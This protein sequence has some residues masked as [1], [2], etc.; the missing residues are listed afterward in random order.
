VA[1]RQETGDFIRTVGE[2]RQ[3]V[4]G[5]ELDKET[6]YGWT[7][8]LHANVLN[9]KEQVCVLSFECEYD[10]VLIR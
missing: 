2:I 1:S 8:V 4:S 10:E 3:N 6:Q 9:D 5:H 7:F